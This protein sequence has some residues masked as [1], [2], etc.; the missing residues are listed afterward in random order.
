MHC[1]KPLLKSLH[2]IDYAL[3]LPLLKSISDGVEPID[4]KVISHSSIENLSLN[5]VSCKEILTH[6]QYSPPLL[7][8]K[9]HSIP[10]QIATKSL[11]IYAHESLQWT[12][13]S[14]SMT[15]RYTT[16]SATQKIRQHHTLDLVVWLKF[17]YNTPIKLQHLIHYTLPKKWHGAHITKIKSS[18][19]DHKKV[20]TQVVYQ[21][22]STQ[23]LSKHDLQKVANHKER[24]YQQKI[25]DWGSD[26]GGGQLV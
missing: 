3:P 16:S 25:A 6:W 20:H 12:T 21:R 26:Q 11:M 17:S 7:S 18:T 15:S 14:T 23:D 19:W 9:P 10:A 13:K 4:N 24:V 22:P 1:I 8:S 5:H 2:A